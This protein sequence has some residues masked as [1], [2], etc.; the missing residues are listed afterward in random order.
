ML[1]VLLPWIL[2]HPQKND[3]TVFSRNKGKQ[4]DVFQKQIN[5]YHHLSLDAISVIIFMPRC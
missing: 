3:G 1:M 2:L 5:S 4:L